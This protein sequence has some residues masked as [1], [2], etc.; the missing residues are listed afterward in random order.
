MSSGTRSDQLRSRIYGAVLGENNWEAFLA[1]LTT[2]LPEGRAALFFHDIDHRAG[3]FSLVSNLMDEKA[4]AYNAHYAPKNPWMKGAA[5]RPVGLVVPDQYMLSREEVEKTEFYC[6]WLR[7]QGLRGA[8][9]VTLHREGGHNSLL[10]VISCK[11]DVHEYQDSLRSLQ[12][13]VPD[14]QRV[15]AFY[16]RQSSHAPMLEGGVGSDNGVLTVGRDRKVTFMND[17][18]QRILTEGS[19]IGLSPTSR[20]RSIDSCLTEWIDCCLAF[21]GRS[22]AAPPV[23]SFLVGRPPAAPTR[24]TVIS[25]ARD[26][27][28]QFFRGP[29]CHL[30]VEP[31]RARAHSLS[32]IGRF[33]KLTPME[34]KVCAYLTT[35]ASPAE[36]ADQLGLGVATVR[37][38]LKSA[39]QK[40]GTSRQAEL[41]SLVI[42]FADK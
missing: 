6:D 24:I 21:W 14:L 1:D 34:E 28:E 11:R 3:A 31:P 4:L 33:Y 23:R 32:A 41:V 26:S 36:I 25:V 27:G 35:G 8:I 5:E 7:P 39:F 22:S 2:L 9:G 37:T 29:E 19:V 30:I 12:A 15:M 20:L 17:R 13:V 16:R 10:S 42:Q 18:A 40:T 38:H